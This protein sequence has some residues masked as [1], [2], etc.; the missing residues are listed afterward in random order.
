MDGGGV[1]GAGGWS[2][3]SLPAQRHH[4]AVTRLSGHHVH[5]LPP[6]SL[7]QTAGAAALEP[8]AAPVP[9]SPPDHSLSVSQRARLCYTQGT[10]YVI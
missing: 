7:L 6:S 3:Q 8:R 9:V 5:H 2:S 1:H 4:R 10:S